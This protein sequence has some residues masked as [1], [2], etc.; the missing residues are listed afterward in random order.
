MKQISFNSSIIDY[1]L[2]KPQPNTH[3]TLSPRS[4]KIIKHLV[5]IYKIIVGIIINDVHCHKRLLEAI[6]S[7]FRNSMVNPL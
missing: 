7:T 4:K 2:Q 5:N 6:T 1:K 3:T